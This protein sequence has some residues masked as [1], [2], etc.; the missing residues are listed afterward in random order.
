MQNIGQEGYVIIRFT[1]VMDMI[2]S[3]LQHDTLYGGASLKGQVAYADMKG[4]GIKQCIVVMIFIKI[5]G[6]QGF[7]QGELSACRSGFPYGAHR[8]ERLLLS[9]PARSGP[10]PIEAG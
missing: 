7:A 8:Q 6:C 5:P 2:K 10:F 3:I 1:L 9:G 4:S